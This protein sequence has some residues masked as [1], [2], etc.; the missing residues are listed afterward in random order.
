VARSAVILVLVVTA[1][2][3][4]PPPRT[5]NDQPR[6]PPKSSTPI[7][8][9]V[10]RQADLG[11]SAEQAEA[12]SR[13]DEGVQQLNKPLQDELGTVEHRPESPARERGSGGSWGRGGG[14]RGG[15]RMQ[16]SAPPASSPPSA[17]T[18]GGDGHRQARA[19][20][21]RAKMSENE[22][23]A[24]AEAICDLDPG[25]RDKARKVLDD[26]GYEWPESLPCD[27]AKPAP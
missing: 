9:L 14:R 12:L 11:L 16:A 22:L 23:R 26:E 20:E 13:L 10:E 15:R 19:E 6:L 7:G 4:A 5:A 25:Q 27:P 18:S 1:C 24:L 21:L 17:A 2:A 8:L 3:G